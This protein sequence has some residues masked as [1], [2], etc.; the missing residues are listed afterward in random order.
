[1]GP[2][3]RDRQLAFLFKKKKIKKDGIKIM[4]KVKTQK[5]N[6]FSSGAIYR[7]D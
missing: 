1:M 7:Y 2:G 6:N 5:T 3:V 4:N